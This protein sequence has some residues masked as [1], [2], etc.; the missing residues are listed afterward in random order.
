MQ[1]GKNERSKKWR[2]NNS[3]KESNKGKEL[4]NYIKTLRNTENNEKKLNYF[5]INK[6][7]IRLF[8]EF[9]S[10]FWIFHGMLELNWILADIY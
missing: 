4:R 10:I 1:L 3:E 2:N 5:L 8:T 6:F 7:F 9:W